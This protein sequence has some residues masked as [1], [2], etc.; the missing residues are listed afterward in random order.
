MRECTLNC[1]FK[2]S[3]TVNEYKLF[4]PLFKTKKTK[5]LANYTNQKW[6]CVHF[7][8]NTILEIIADIFLYT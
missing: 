7:I 6:E 4:K 5:F 2:L 8:P 1:D 3:F